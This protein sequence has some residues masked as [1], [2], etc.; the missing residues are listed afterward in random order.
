MRGLGGLCR[1]GQKGTIVVSRPSPSKTSRSS[2]RR[3]RPSSEAASPVPS[4]SDRGRRLVGPY[5]ARS[6]AASVAG[7]G[8]RRSTQSVYGFG[9]VVMDMRGS[10]SAPIMVWRERPPVRGHRASGQSDFDSDDELTSTCGAWSGAG[11]QRLQSTAASSAAQIWRIR[12]LLRVPRRSTSTLTDTLSTESRFTAVVR[13]T[14][15]S[16]GSRRTSLGRFRTVVV[17]GPTRVRRSRGMAASRDRT[18]TG[19]RPTSGSS[20]HQSS[21]R[22]GGPLTS[23]QPLP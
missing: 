12:S 3:R 6:H 22:R 1:A 17:Q 9:G 20:H 10:Q 7:A 14:G 15:S 13:G 4:P 5:G 21:P 16:P 19:R 8:M 18:T 23:R 2:H 11:A